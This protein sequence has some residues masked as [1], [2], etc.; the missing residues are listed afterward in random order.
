MTSVPLLAPHP[1]F[2]IGANDAGFVPCNHVGFSA[3][4]S[5]RYA[6]NSTNPLLPRRPYAA[7]PDPMSHPFQDFDAIAVS[8]AV[9]ATSEP[10]S[11]VP[12]D[13]FWDCERAGMRGGRR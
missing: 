8:G 11:V 4:L 3:A 5:A 13:L 1:G 2:V 10:P 7:F 6:L 12:W 9:T